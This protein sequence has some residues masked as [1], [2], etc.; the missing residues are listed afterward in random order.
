[1]KLIVCLDS[2]GGW[3]FYGKRLS[4]DITAS[5]RIAEIVEDKRVWLTESSRKLFEELIPCNQ[6]STIPDGFTIN[7][8]KSFHT[9]YCFAENGR[10]L[11]N[12]SIFSEAI[13]FRWDKPYPY[14]EKMLIDFDSS[15]RWTKISSKTFLGYSHK[16]ILEEHYIRSYKQ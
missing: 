4:K 14:D 10:I 7:D 11:K 6:L 15:P 5:A 9:D 2:R 8:V 12:I 13:V 3:S 1:M 16:E